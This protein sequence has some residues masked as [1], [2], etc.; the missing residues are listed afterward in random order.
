MKLRV[1]K[2]SVTGPIARLT[3]ACV[4]GQGGGEIAVP[5]AWAAALQS[6]LEE[7]PSSHFRF[8]ESAEEAQAVAA[9]LGEPALFYLGTGSEPFVQ[10]AVD[11]GGGIQVGAIVDDCV[12]AILWAQA[13]GRW[14]HGE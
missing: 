14:Q 4:G 13:E 11:P 6:H 3:L 5:A 9:S 12:S 7:F 2:C 10:A 1:I 8:A